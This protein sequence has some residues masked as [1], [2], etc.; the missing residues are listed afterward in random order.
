MAR[1]F[2]KLLARNILLTRRLIDKC[3]NS[4]TASSMNV[5]PTKVGIIT[6]IKG[7]VFE[8]INKFFW[9]N[10]YANTIHCFNKFWGKHLVRM[11]FLN[12]LT[13]I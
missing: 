7:L 1:I 13:I 5:Y 11:P 6:K 12:K 3:C 9:C 10:A 8:W 4:Y 2:S